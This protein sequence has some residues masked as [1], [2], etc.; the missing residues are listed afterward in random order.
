[1]HTMHPLPLTLS[2]IFISTVVGTGAPIVALTY[3]VFQGALDGNL[4]TFLGVPFAKP[5]IR[6]SLPQAPTLLDG[7]QNATAFGPACPQQIESLPSA[8]PPFPDEG[9]P[10]EDCLKLN[11]FG[12]SSANRTS[13]LPVLV[14]IYGGGF[15]IGNAPDTDVRPLV[16][17]SIVNGEP[18][19]VVTIN[20]RLSAW[21]FLGGK[22][23]ADAGISNL[24]LRDQIF[25]LEWVQAH[26]TAFGGDPARVV[27]GGDSAGAISAS[28][29]LL[30]NNRFEITT[31]ARGAFLL[32]GSPITTG[33]VADGQPHYDGLVRANNCTQAEDTLACLRDVPLD[34]FT[35]TVNETPNLFSF[36]SL[37]NVWRARV[38]GD[39]IARDPLISVSKG[40]FANIPVMTGDSDDEGTIFSLSN[41]NITTDDEFVSYIHS[42]Y[43]PKA[44]PEQ[45]AQLAVLYPDNP[46]QG[47]PFDTESA[48]QVTPQF[49]RLAAFQGDYVFTGARRNFLSSASRTQNTWSWLNKRGKSAPVVGSFHTSDIN[50]WFPLPNSTDFVAADAL[51]NFINHLDPNGGRNTSGLFWPKWSQSANGSTPSLFTL[52]DPGVVSITPEN[53]RV[54]AIDFLLQVLLDGAESQ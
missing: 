14:W 38:D 22:E 10:S 31:L 39:V 23:A 43:L 46:T 26:I 1:M 5:A 3:G 4:S 34:S 28:M 30:S 33:T 7:L 41:T 51:I 54:E 42:I 47:S 13:K 45:L 20:Y 32:S 48:N 21:G 17:R 16:E 24:G 52:S 2:A 36:S 15:E 50:I 44:T 29:L 37:Q 18:V 40:L 12:P 6:F 49:K 19:I 53:F 27:F 8:L 11:V 9:L 35:A 25:A